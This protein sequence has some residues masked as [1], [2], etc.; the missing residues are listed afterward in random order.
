ME[1]IIC[2][3]NEELEMDAA[4]VAGLI[5]ANE[6][7]ETITNIHYIVANFWP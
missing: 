7:K 4:L 2:V 5:N 3:T 6:N 1:E